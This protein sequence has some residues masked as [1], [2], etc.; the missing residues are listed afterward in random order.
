MIGN[1]FGTT[2][3]FFRVFSRWDGW[4]I[5]S[6]LGVLEVLGKFV[7]KKTQ[8]SQTWVKIASCFKTGILLGLFIDGFK[9]GS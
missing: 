6:L 5:L 7:Y 1:L 2:L 8:N 9:V 3:D 4:I